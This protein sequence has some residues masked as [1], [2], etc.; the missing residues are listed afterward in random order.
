[1]KWQD[2]LTDVEREKLARLDRIRQ[3]ARDAFAAER[4]LLKS[5]AESRM[6]Y[7]AKSEAQRKER[8]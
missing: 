4:R 5:R 8:E 6:R 7:R 3:E 2:Y 1:M